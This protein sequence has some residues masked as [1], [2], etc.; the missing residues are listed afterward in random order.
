MK[1]TK[2]TLIA[3]ALITALTL[4]AFASCGK[5]GNTDLPANDETQ[6]EETKTEE[7]Q[8][9]SSFNTETPIVSS[10]NEA[11]NTQTSAEE[12]KEN[13]KGKKPEQHIV[14]HKVRKGDTVAK[15]AK[16]YGVSINQ[17]C[18]LNGLTQKQASRIKIGQ[19]IRVK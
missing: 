10:E 13:I 7:N 9:P 3:L 19:I 12:I 14:N 6:N 1:N 5:D 16:K 11:I 17:I 2:L 18:K 8:T 4:F 15:I